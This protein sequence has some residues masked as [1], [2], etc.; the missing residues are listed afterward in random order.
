LSRRIRQHRSR[1]KIINDILAVARHGARKTH[2]MYRANLSY[3]Q[4]N[5]YLS[6]LLDNGLI[7]KEADMEYEGA[8]IYKVTQKGR[9]FLERY[10]QLQDI[11]AHPQPGQKVS[12]N[13]F[14][15]PA[16]GE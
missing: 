1:L 5:E 9:Q 10:S 7:E 16:I 15:L 4:L 11:L 13:Y 2:I 12:T 3:D 8:V 6:F 14:D